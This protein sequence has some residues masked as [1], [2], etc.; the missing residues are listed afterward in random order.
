M[1]ALDPHGSMIETCAGAMCGR[2]TSGVA[3]ILG[4]RNKCDVP[5]QGRGGRDAAFG[6]SQGETAAGADL[7]GSSK[8]SNEN[9]E[10]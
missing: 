8:Y 4:R 9:F 5:E 7:G 6:A 1:H 2:R 10:D 3:P